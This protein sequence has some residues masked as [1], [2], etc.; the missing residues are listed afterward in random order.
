MSTITIDTNDDVKVLKACRGMLDV[1]IGEERPL[2]LNPNAI[3]DAVDAAVERDLALGEAEV[4]TE[5]VQVAPA[6]AHYAS[7]VTPREV[8]TNGVAF[9]EEFCG[10]AGDP[11]YSSGKR[12]GQW[13][14]RRGVTDE[15]YDY[16]YAAQAKSDADTETSATAEDDEPVNTAGAFGADTAAAPDANAPTDCGSFM[17]WVSAKQAA[18]LLTQDDIGEA[19]SQV[20]VAVTDLFPPNDPATIEKHVTA[21]YVILS[22]KAGA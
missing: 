10:K 4:E 1:L 11:F 5:G 12:K 14:K 15:Q 9:N 20:E 16:W 17:G 8:D 21:L 19:Y 13:K 2:I 6:N 22:A 18:E 3:S 7:G